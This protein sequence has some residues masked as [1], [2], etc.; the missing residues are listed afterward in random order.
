MKPYR[1]CPSF[2]K[3][4][5]NICPLDPEQHLRTYIKGEDKCRTEKPT[6]MKIGSK[7]P[8]V[9]PYQGLTKREFKGRERWNALTPQERE[10]FTQQGIKRLKSLKLKGKNGILEKSTTLES[11]SNA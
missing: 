10:S 11:I 4:S 1:E 2:G 5:A 9:L 3:Y 7:Y 8:D 6:R